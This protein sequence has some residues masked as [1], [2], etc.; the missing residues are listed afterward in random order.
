[1]AQFPKLRVFAGQKFY[2]MSLFDSKVV[3]EIQ[4]QV[5]QTNNE[6]VTQFRQFIS[7]KAKKILTKSLV[8][9]REKLRK[10]RLRQKD[11]FHTRKRVY[12]RRIMKLNPF[13]SVSNT[14]SVLFPL[15]QRSRKS[16]N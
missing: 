10:L 2:I 4:I 16:R 13:S 6:N 5:Y 15:F 1:M 14:L 11:G 12:I 8:Y 9:F 3:N 7:V